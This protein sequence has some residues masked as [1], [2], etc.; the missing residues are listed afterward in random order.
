PDGSFDTVVCT[1]TL[2]SVDDPTSVLSELRRI[3]AQ[4]GRLLF[5][6]HGRAPD[7]VVARWQER[8]EPVWK[9][10]AGGCHLTRPIGSAL[11]AAGFAVEP[12]GQAYLN[13]AP[14]VMGWMEW[15][16]ARKA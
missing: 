5:L 6:E 8:I 7:A 1:Y 11:R 3:L 2:C 9:P 12:L 13:K 16:V 10:L 15:G 14:K 4:N